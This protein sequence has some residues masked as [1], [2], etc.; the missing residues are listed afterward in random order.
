MVEWFLDAIPGVGTVYRSGKAVV[1]HI[2][3]DHEAAQREWAEAGANAAGDAIGLVTGGAGKVASVAAKTGL[4]VGAKVAV[5]QGAKVAMKQAGKAAVKAA[6]KQMTK[7]SMKSY[8]KKYLKK[9]VK[10]ATKKALK[11]ARKK[12]GEWVSD[13]SDDESDEDDDTFRE[14]VIEC[15]RQS[16][17]ASEAYLQTLS[18]EQLAG[19]YM[20]QIGRYE[21]DEDDY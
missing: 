14:N 2:Q 21:D 5:K 9:K 10:K 13:D 11:D 17:Y 12:A 1:N 20:E 4:K 7:K 6:G 18:N 19:I 8:A 16:G 15:L 3:G